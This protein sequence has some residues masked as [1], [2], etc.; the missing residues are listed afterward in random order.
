MIE[1]FVNVITPVFALV[2]IGYLAGN[3][4][5][6]D[7]R[8]LSKV[9]YYVFVPAFV[10]EIMSTADIKAQEASRMF[11]YILTVTISSALLGFVI[12]KAL[13][14]PVPVVGAYVL[15]A[16][17]GNI[18]NFGLP[19]IEFRLGAEAMVPATFYF[20]VLNMSG[21]V[22]GVFAASWA[23]G[24]NK[25][26]VLSV[27]KTPALIAVVFALL[28]N[29]LP[30]ESPLVVE[31][32]I[33]LLS[34][35]MI[36]IMLITLGVK[37]FNTKQIHITRDVVFA[38]SIKLI[39]APAIAVALAALFGISG[40]S[41]SA[42]IMQAAMPAAVLTSIIAIE[43]DLVPDFVTTTVLFSTLASVFTLTFILA[44]L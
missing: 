31:R 37:L 25:T 12:A 3:Y 23:T 2:I 43:H 13:K 10:F 28:V 19:L 9:A 26:A 18:G 42:G 35:A 11:I 40:L 15:I 34:A 5:H 6:L 4:L 1:V 30:V 32:I 24:G 8:T 16:A 20:L 22:I 39:G 14:R 29:Q 33:S 21:F 41:R 36:P 38:S 27:L 44:L 17:F 7:E